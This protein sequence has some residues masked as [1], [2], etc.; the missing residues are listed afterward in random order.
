[1]SILLCPKPVEITRKIGK[2]GQSKGPGIARS[3]GV[4][5]TK[6]YSTVSVIVSVVT[7]APYLSVIT[8]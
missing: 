7:E 1:M 4:N 8:Q 3:F 2:K 6:D 5:K